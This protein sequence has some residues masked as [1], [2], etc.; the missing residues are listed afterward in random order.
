MRDKLQE[1]VTKKDIRIKELMDLI[2][3]YKE[4]LKQ[5]ELKNAKLELDC[6]NFKAELEEHIHISDINVRLCLKL[7]QVEVGTCQPRTRIQEN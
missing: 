4:D 7:G 1:E 2:L 3:Q 5:L 6:E